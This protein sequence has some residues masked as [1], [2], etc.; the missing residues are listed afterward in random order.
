MGNQPEQYQNYKQ[1]QDISELHLKPL[2]DPLRSI[3][4]RKNDQADNQQCQ[5]QRSD[6]F[7]GENFFHQM[8]YTNIRKAA[9]HPVPL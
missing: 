8:F 6:V 9:I 2:I 7:P 4:D 3:I 1:D 5:Q